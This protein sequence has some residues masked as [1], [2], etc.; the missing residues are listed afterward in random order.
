MSKI[1]SVAV[2]CASSLGNT[3]EFSEAAFNLAHAMADQ[4]ID[5]VF[6]GMN[7][8]LMK[9]VADEL[10]SCGR[11][12]TGVIPRSFID[13]GVVYPKLTSTIIADT[14]A[15]RKSKMIELAD[16]F[17]ALPGGLG[18]FSEIFEVWSFAQLGIVPKPCAFFNISSFYDLM[19]QFL[20]HCVES[21]F[22][23]QAH[24]DILFSS[25]SPNLILEYF[26]NYMP[27]KVSKN[28]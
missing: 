27:T 5:L 2:Y 1:L 9:I 24:R 17:I 22:I 14:I 6:G 4:G 11:K 18:T 8:G 15:E 26:S 16:G 3:T 21:G 28:V 19:M 12:I 7:S 20:D 13:R 10:S 23:K 25:D